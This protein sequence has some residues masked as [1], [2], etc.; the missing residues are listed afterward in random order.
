MIT[1]F[2]EIL[3]FVLFF[4][5]IYRIIVGYKALDAF[6]VISVITIATFGEALNLLVFKATAYT[7]RIGVPVYIILGGA[8]IGWVYYKLPCVIAQKLNR[9]NL[10]VRI[11]LFLLLSLLFP[12]IEICGIKLGLWH[13]LKPYSLSSIWWWIGVWKFYILFLGLVPLTG[14][15]VHPPSSPTGNYGG[16]VGRG[17]EGRGNR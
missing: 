4:L 1:H 7:G 14:L 15:V 6:L 13:W 11:G 9:D 2:I 10:P 3:T 5:L 17:A 12:V 8:L 16:Q